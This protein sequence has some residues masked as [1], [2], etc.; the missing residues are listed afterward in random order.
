MLKQV[1]RMQQQMAKIQEELGQETVTAS[2]GG[3]AV[4]VTMT[5]HQV[6][7]QV[8]ISPEVVDPADVEMLEELVMSAFNEAHEKSQALATKR[9]GALTGGLKIPGLM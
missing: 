7:T 4:T 9:L 2:V 8:K 6:V 3:G 5:G 1:Q